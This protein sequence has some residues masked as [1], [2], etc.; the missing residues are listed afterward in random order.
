V[1]VYEYHTVCMK[2]TT[3]ELVLEIT[4]NYFISNAATSSV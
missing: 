4:L 1:W 3:E 2:D